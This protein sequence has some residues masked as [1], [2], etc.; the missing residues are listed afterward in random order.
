M[1]EPPK[2]SGEL[3]HYGVKGMRWGQRKAERHAPNAKYSP[4]QRAYDLKQRGKGG[5]K[6][7]NRNLNKG[8]TLKK[9]RS[10]ETSFRT[11]RAAAVTA[12]L[13]YGPKA[14]RLIKVVGPMFLQVAAVSVAG[15][16]ETNRGRAQ[17]AATMGLPRTASTG[18]NY[19]KRNRGGAYNISSL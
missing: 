12:G 13:Y 14:V 16:A 17:A 3:V 1:S 9:A 6:R 2:P 7:V 5:V 15:R 19:A 18:P 11:K 4:N 8:M 10:K